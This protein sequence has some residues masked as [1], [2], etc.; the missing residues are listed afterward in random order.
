M[1]SV[2]KQLL[3]NMQRRTASV[4]IGASTIRKMVPAGSIQQIRAYLA[5]FDLASFAKVEPADFPKWLD[6]QTQAFQNRGLKNEK[7]PWGV[8]RKCLNIFLRDAA[9]NF[10]L[11]DRYNLS[12]VEYLLEVPLDSH[13][14][15]SLEAAVETLNGFKSVKAV[16]WKISARYQEVAREVAQG[17]GIARVH[18][19]LEYWRPKNGLSPVWKTGS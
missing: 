10:M 16:D 18:L 6:Q 14:A 3:S 11:R 19:D 2:E 17:K 7:I 4:S 9:Y 13:V 15:K 12:R 5:A 1:N 8:A